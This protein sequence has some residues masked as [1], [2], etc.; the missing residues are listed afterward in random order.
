MPCVGVTLGPK[1]GLEGT[2]DSD[3]LSDAEGPLLAPKMSNTMTSREKL[4]GAIY[5]K[6]QRPGRKR[7]AGVAPAPVAAPTK[8]KKGRPASSASVNVTPSTAA[9]TPASNSVS[10]TGASS[11][12]HLPLGGAFTYSYISDF[13]LF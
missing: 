2:S 3:E 4:M 5:G 6:V 13:C 12:S 8:V 10:D 1:E 7:K 11:C 9:T